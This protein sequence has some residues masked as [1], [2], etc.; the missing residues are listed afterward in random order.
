[1]I[2]SNSNLGVYLLIAMMAMAISMAIIPLMMRLAPIIGMIDAPDPRKVHSVPIP[3]V[4]GL[5]IVIGALVPMLVWLPFTDLTIS[6][7]FRCYDFAHI[8]YLG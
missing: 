3:R 8:W 4:G 1:M 6:I 5:G 2:I 7:F